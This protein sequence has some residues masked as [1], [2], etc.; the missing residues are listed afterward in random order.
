MMGVQMARVV[1]RRQRVVGVVMVMAVEIQEVRVCLSVVRGCGVVVMMMMVVVIAA[2][3]AAADIGR[4][5]EMQFRLPGSAFVLNRCVQV[6][7]DD[8][9]LIVISDQCGQLKEAMQ[10][11]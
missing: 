2:A 6:F 1:R 7:G 8:F 4:V 11:K 3:A 5:Q 9:I 10:L